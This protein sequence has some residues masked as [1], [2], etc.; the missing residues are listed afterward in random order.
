MNRE[1]H[2]G[3]KKLAFTFI[4][5]LFLMTF[6]CSI[7][8]FT[9]ND[10]T[11]SKLIEPVT[12]SSL[13][14][15]IILGKKL[16]NANSVENMQLA[17]EVLISRGINVTEEI[18]TTHYY[19]RFEPQNEDQV[20]ELFNDQELNLS[21]IPLDYEVLTNGSK[22][23]DPNLT[24][25]QPDYLY[26]TVKIDKSLPDVPF[27]IL[28]N[29]YLTDNNELNN[30]SYKLTGNDKQVNTSR[31]T[32][33]SIRGRI[34]IYDSTL[35]DYVPVPLLE[36]KV[37][38]GNV[39]KTAT[40]DMDGYYVIDDKDSNFSKYIDSIQF[41]LRY[42]NKFSIRKSNN[43]YVFCN[44][45]FNYMDLDI[46]PRDGD[47]HFYTK[48]YR[49]AVL[50]YKHLDKYRKNPFTYVP[51]KAYDH[52]KFWPSNNDKSWVGYYNGTNNTV[53]MANKY[54]T[55][56]D[57]GKETVHTYD[58]L[59]IFQIMCH[60]LGHAMHDKM[61]EN[62][63]L[64]STLVKEAFA[65]F[66]AWEMV[67]KYFTD[68]IFV[69]SWG[70]MTNTGI[71]KQRW[72]PNGSDH[73]TP[74][75]ID[76]VDTYNQYNISDDYLNDNVFGYKTLNIINMIGDK[77]V[78]TLPTVISRIKRWPLPTYLTQFERDQYFEQYYFKPESVFKEDFSNGWNGWWH[79]SGG[80][81]RENDYRGDGVQAFVKN[82]SRKNSKVMHTYISNRG[83][84]KYS[85]YIRS[86]KFQV[87]NGNKYIVK[88]KAWTEFDKNYNQQ[89][90]ISVGFSISDSKEVRISEDYNKTYQIEV[91]ATYTGHDK[92]EF[93]IGNHGKSYSLDVIIDDIEIIR[94]SALGN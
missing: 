39:I 36:I 10:D 35:K 56:D 1:L 72:A 24:G 46:I 27:T 70:G 44:I 11:N 69:T 81:T 77:S 2:M 57:K 50:C 92:I 41:H 83:S 6:S 9:E 3:L 79:K 16:K 45:N 7:Q 76:L 85:I 26:S 42:S 29:L 55:F 38:K 8:G 82:D 19:V 60:E 54:S 53:Y 63:S 73:Y 68:S 5:A 90:N 89:R 20:D 62:Y 58:D 84:E 64:V 80:K 47:L 65:N 25:S 4:I 40:T 93:Y 37:R 66:I 33:R 13:D 14:G 59:T 49:A 28:E 34:R 78:K 21:L 52:K 61:N 48:L 86:P 51:I 71:S 74:F 12:Q 32:G 22:Y 87:E 91:N 15:E 30:E 94:A 43:N 31:G 17:K 67:S 23:R 18:K 75:F 88:F